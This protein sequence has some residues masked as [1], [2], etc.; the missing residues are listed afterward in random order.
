M[1]WNYTCLVREA[2]RE[3][4]PSFCSRAVAPLILVA[5]DNIF[6]WRLMSVRNSGWHMGLSAISNSNAACFT[7][8]RGNDV[9]KGRSQISDKRLLASS[10]LALR[11]HGTTWLPLGGFSLSLILEYFVRKICQENSGLLKCDKNNG[12]F[13]WRLMYIYANISL[14]SS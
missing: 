8:T 11:P 13:T 7:K 5:P 10:C 6:T 1:F 14:N 9:C 3:A 12:Y 4:Q 2:T